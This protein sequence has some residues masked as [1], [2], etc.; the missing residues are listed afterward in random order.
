MYGIIDLSAVYRNFSAGAYI[1]AKTPA[2]NY[3][4][5]FKSLTLA[6]G[7]KAAYVQQI[8]DGY[9]LKF[10]AVAA[11]NYISGSV[12]FYSN[13]S[14]LGFTF[15]SND[16]T[17]SGQQLIYSGNNPGNVRGINAK[18]NLKVF[19]FVLDINHS[20]NFRNDR[21]QIIP[22]NFGRAEL[23]FD[24]IAFRNKLEYR[25]GL[26][27]R[28]WQ[29]HKAV[30]YSSMSNSFNEYYFGHSSYNYG[31]KTGEIPANATLDFFI[32]GKIGRA[33]FGITLENILDRLIYNTG[34]Y[35]FMDRGGL[36][37]AISR[38]NITWNF[39]D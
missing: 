26:S 21:N 31:Y 37:N 10:S 39:F 33:T 1:R 7:L 15:Y 17:I 38:F 35:P 24:D 11:Y 9:R 22:E 20:Y 34:V 4:E 14:D 27:S 13:W 36:L 3:Y 8:S 28:Y 5:F 12:D 18:I 16:Y 30:Y 32:M 23:S 25:I 2:Y 19:R 29:K 6:S